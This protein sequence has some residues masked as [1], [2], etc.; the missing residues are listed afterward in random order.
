MFVNIPRVYNFLDNLI[1]QTFIV[2]IV[3]PL[4]DLSIDTQNLQK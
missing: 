2:F 3:A 4:C 1:N